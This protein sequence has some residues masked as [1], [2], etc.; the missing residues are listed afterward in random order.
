MNRKVIFTFIA[1]YGLAAGLGFFLSGD[2]KDESAAEQTAS[3]ILQGKSTEAVIEAVQSVN[4]EITHELAII[5][6]VAATLTL[7][8][9][10]EL[11]V[12]P[13]ILDISKDAPVKTAGGTAGGSPNAYA[14]FPPR[15]RRP[16]S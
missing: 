8:Q 13:A 9:R 5:N 16:G 2:S 1:I 10:D 11:L 15:W 4:G 7:P 3:Y 6:A 14:N 12:N